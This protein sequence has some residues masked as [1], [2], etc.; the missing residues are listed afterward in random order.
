M[1]YFSRCLFTYRSSADRITA[2]L[3]S[4]RSLLERRRADPLTEENDSSAHPLDQQRN[5]DRNDHHDDHELG[6]PQSTHGTNVAAPG[7]VG[8]QNSSPNVI[9]TTTGTNRG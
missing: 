7:I 8:G 6:H 2:E 4:P 9:S 5:G 3:L 1:T